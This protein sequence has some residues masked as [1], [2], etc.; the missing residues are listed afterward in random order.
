MFDKIKKLSALFLVIIFIF[1]MSTMAFA[2]FAFEEDA[3]TTIVTGSDFQ[4]YGTKAYDRF[5]KVL[6][7]MKNDG[8]PTPDAMLMGGDFTKI[9]FDYAT[10]GMTLIKKSFTTVYPDAKEDSVIMIQGNHDNEVSGFTKTGFYD[11]GTYC[12]YCINEHDFPWLQTIRCSTGVKKVAK[13]LEENLDKMINNGDLRPVII[14]TH[15]PLHHTTRSFGSDNRYSSYLFDVIN[16]K[17]ET[18]DIVFLFG[19]N[20]SKGYD[21]YI[22]GSVNF[23]KPG[24]IIRIPDAKNPGKSNYSE[25]TLNFTYTNCGY[26]GYSK[27]SV[28][29]TSTNV[30]TLG[31][32]QLTPNKISFTK[33]SEEGLFSTQ[34]VER[35]NIGEEGKSNTTS[36]LQNENLWY[37]FQQ[38]FTKLFDVL[39]KIKNIF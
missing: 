32:I 36:T 38:L 22:G 14:M 20:H 17:A 28:S 19:H 29:E 7:V 21:D 18:L 31:S 15:V 5:E 33:Y 39:A 25:E 37:K 4:E 11:M 24:D 16:K 35:K 9:L 23:M 26:I 1:S 3:Y 8:M 27:N 6:T 13:D 2:E 12:L 30:L 10:P 34:S